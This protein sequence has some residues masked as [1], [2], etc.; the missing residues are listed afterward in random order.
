[1]KPKGTQFELS[2]DDMDKNVQLPMFMHAQELR[3]SVTTTADMPVRSVDDV[4]EFKVTNALAPRVRGNHGS[5]VYES[6]Q[7]EGVKSPVQLAHGD[8]DIMLGQGHHR[9]AAISD[10]ADQGKATNPWVPVVHTDARSGTKHMD[11]D[12]SGYGIRDVEVRRSVIK[13][14]SE[15]EKNTGAY[16]RSDKW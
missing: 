8:E 9:V 7:K 3:D 16:Y 2:A 15:F 11:Q 12:D 13:D 5:G 6:V 4:M 1:V 14:M 10:Q